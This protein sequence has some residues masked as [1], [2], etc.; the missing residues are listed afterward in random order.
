MTFYVEN[1]TDMNF[2]FSEEEI[3]GSSHRRKLPIR[4]TGKRAFDR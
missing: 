1:D 3:V 4:R 2:S